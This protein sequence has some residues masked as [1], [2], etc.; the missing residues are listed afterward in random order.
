M[1][2]KRRYSARRRKSESGFAMLIIFVFAAAI[3]VSLYTQVPRYAFEAQRQKE[4]LLVDRGE[5]YQRG[6][7]LYVRKLKKYPSSLEDLETTSNVRFLRKRY[8]DP[9]TGESE[10]RIIHVAGGQLTDSLVKK[11]NAND[12]NKS[13]YQNTFITEGP[14]FG[15][16]NTSNQGKLPPGGAL[17][18]SDMQGAPGQM[19]PPGAPT[20][21]GQQLAGN[22]SPNGGYQNP[23]PGQPQYPYP[24][25]GT[26]NP[27]TGQ[28]GNNQTGQY[29]VQQQY[30]GVQQFPGQQPYPGQQP[31]SYQGQQQYP[32]QPGAPP[33]PGFPLVPGQQTIAGQ[34]INQQPYQP[35]MPPGQQQPYQGYQQ[36]NQG[37]NPVNNGQTYPT[38]AATSQTSGFGQQQ[39]GFGQQGMNNPQGQIGG[40]SGIQGNAAN[41]INDLLT[42]PRAGGLPGAG[43]GGG[44]MMGASGIA[45]VASKYEGESIKIY[46][47]SSQ[48]KE[49]EFIYDPSKDKSNSAN[50]AAAAQMNQQQNQQNQNQSGFGSN[51]GSSFGNTN[52]TMGPQ[53]QQSGFGNPPRP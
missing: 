20:G 14:S 45:G 8:K 51:S 29:P 13:T 52:N 39:S 1:I 34:Q 28:Y 38:A 2:T 12:P 11:N 10:W 17:R 3:A 49:W 9:M 15:N 33:V 41:L 25:T 27:Q 4:Q 44:T 47:D 46:N 19:P 48:I 31:T 37:F 16:T 5:Q 21:N 53:P 50:P 18:Q 32:G 36:P 7:Q 40:S 6:I 42:K 24:N 26:Y 22:I 43:I 30:P 23:Q 35:Y